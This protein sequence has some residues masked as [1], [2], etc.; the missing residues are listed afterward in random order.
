MIDND[1]VAQPLHPK[2]CSPGAVLLAHA[3]LCPVAYNREALEILAYPKSPEDLAH[4][5]AD[6][7]RQIGS[8]LLC[9]P[10]HGTPAFVAEFQS[11]NRTYHC[12]TLNVCFSGDQEASPNQ[13]TTLV[14]LER[15][16]SPARQLQRQAWEK[17]GLTPRERQ[18]VEL[19]IAGMTTKEMAQRLH[20]SANTIKSFLR[21]VMAKMGVSTRSGIVGKLL[22]TDSA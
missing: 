15:Q 16:A 20:L 5:S 11:G 22:E 14:L 17:F 18:M 3:S 2:A 6:L 4:P 10:S 21:L 12:R 13:T 8:R 1:A 19:L 9:Q 7:A